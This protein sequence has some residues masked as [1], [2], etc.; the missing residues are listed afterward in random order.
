MNERNDRV[1]SVLSKTTIIHTITYFLMGIIAFNL[2][3]YTEEFSGANLSCYMRQ[4]NDPM[5]MAGVLFQ[6][7]RGILFGLVFYLLREVL[8][9]K[10]NGWFINWVMLVF[11]GILSTFSAAPGS[12][13]GFVYTKL[14]MSQFGLGML[15]VLAQSFL[16]SILTYH[17]V[18]HPQQKWQGWVYGILFVIVLILPVLGLLVTQ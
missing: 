7:I 13:E 12:V 8:F 11:V 4:T 5:V 14:G 3:H 1:W 15:E 16:L 9:A 18:N 10:K 6:P 2:F 17:W